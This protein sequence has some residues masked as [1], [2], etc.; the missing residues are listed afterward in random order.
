MPRIGV[1]SNPKSQFNRQDGLT[2]VTST[3]EDFTNVQ[4]EVLSDFAELDDM[5]DRLIRDDV[6]I[7]AVNGGDGTVQA[8]L[9]ALT[10]RGDDD[11]TPKLAVLQGGMT[12]VIAKDVG[13]SG[14]PAKA[15]G[16]LIDKLQDKKNKGCSIEEMERSLIGLVIDDEKAPVYGMF[17][18]AA[19]FYQAVLMAQENVRPK[20][21]AGNLAS[22]S[23][24]LM[25]LTRLVLG[26]PSA[27]DPLY[28]GEAMAIDMD[29][30]E[31]AENPY[32]LLMATTLDKLMLGLMPFWGGGHETIRYTSVAF[33]PKHLARALLPILR[34]K[35]RPWMKGK[36][37]S[38]WPRCR[39][40]DR[41]QKPGRAGRRNFSPETRSSHTLDRRPAGDVRSV[42]TP[43]G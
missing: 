43:D 24:L 12:N 3:L 21:F 37:L 11:V 28:R 26:R 41:D 10:Q 14:K 34:G 25:V 32:L 39:H 42:L 18:G 17:F 8:V 16:Q 23:S 27:N 2:S 19:G 36:G 9:T 31:G 7:V 38:K 13:M 22:A 29:G 33:P 40:D 6:E 4:H 20:G 5:V 1:I 15:L 35:P 30:R